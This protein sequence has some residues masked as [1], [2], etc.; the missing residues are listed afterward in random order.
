MEEQLKDVFYRLNST[1]S[2]FYNELVEK[3]AQV[4]SDIESRWGVS[5]NEYSNVAEYKRAV[6]Q[7]VYSELMQM[8][9]NTLN[10]LYQNTLQLLGIKEEAG[11]ERVSMEDQAAYLINQV[12]LSELKAKLKNEKKQL[13]AKKA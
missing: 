2:D 1:N 4:F 3:N 12:D 9:A 5:A 8:D 7:Q 11:E 10:Q 6:D 13:E